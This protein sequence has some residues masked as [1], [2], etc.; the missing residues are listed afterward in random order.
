MW[1]GL[2]E[3]GITHLGFMEEIA[4]SRRVTPGFIGRVEA[5]HEKFADKSWDG[6][7]GKGAERGSSQVHD[8]VL[9]EECRWVDR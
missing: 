8:N 7:S 4:A 6:I 3:K 5:K 9:V 1:C 2:S